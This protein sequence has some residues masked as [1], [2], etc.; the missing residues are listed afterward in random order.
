MKLSV[1]VY[2]AK[3]VIVI[4]GKATADNTSP[5]IS[6]DTNL[7]MTSNQ[8]VSYKVRM[9]SGESAGAVSTITSNTT[10][11]L[12]ISTSAPIPILN[13]DDFEIFT[14]E[15]H[16][17]D[18]FKDEKI[19]MTSQIGNANDIGKL[20]T[21]YSQSFTIPASKTN[22]EILSHWYESSVDNGFDHRKRY[23]AYIEINTHRF[24]N[25]TVQLEKAEKKD[26][27]I[28]SYSITFYGTL[29]QLKDI[30]KD[31]KMQTLSF[32]LASQ[33]N[34]TNIISFITDAFDYGVKFP[35]IGSQNKYEYQTASATDIT[36]T[37]GAIKW[38]DLFPAL[39][40][41]SI[42]QKIQT[43]YGITFTGSFF[44]LDQWT[45]LYLYLKNAL[46]M[47]YV[48]N[49]EPLNFTAISPAPFIAFPEFNLTTD[50]LTTNWNFGST[51]G[52]SQYYS[53]NVKITPT[54]SVPY[55]LYAYKDGVL[56]SAT[57]KAGTQTIGVD[58]VRRRNDPTL[59]HKYTFKIANTGSPFTYTAQLNYT[60][61]WFD[62]VNFLWE[63]RIS[64]AT[65][66]S[67]VGTANINLANYMP[68]MKIIDFITGI[69]KT[70]NLMIIPRANNTY[71]F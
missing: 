28:E 61:G 6:I 46:K 70:F 42:F 45:K 71:E 1:E 49:P 62:Y 66:P 16:R 40:V 15:Y 64:R 34:S 4:S 24:K 29:V 53:V 48:S 36:T 39:K 32:P 25:G 50:T 3:E 10:T 57:K 35:L 44:N 56:L 55:I 8:Y 31:D 67:T 69:I 33:Y 63:N 43:N 41:S 20:Y 22:N 23:D 19:S 2:I 47:E 27:F 58:V 7:T 30:I 54:T 38:N 52:N 68:D 11:K 51:S 59:S 21:D 9:T 26:G 37:T 5:F 60:R 18:L 65:A 14:T 13:G 17:L 12:N